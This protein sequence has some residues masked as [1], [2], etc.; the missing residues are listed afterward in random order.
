MKSIQNDF[1]QA[2]E[3]L[4]DANCDGL[5]LH[6]CHSNLISQFLNKNIN[7]MLSLFSK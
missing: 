2:Y 6:G 1:I 4:Y 7:N 3:V 5:E